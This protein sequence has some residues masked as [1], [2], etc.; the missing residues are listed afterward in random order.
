MGKTREHDTSIRAESET[1]MKPTYE[2]SQ[3]A[4]RKEDRNANAFKTRKTREHVTSSKTEHG[5][6]IRPSQVESKIK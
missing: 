6:W 5:V 3:Q 1:Y 2:I 4:K